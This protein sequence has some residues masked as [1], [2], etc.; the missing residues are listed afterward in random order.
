MNTTQ[1]SRR[2]AKLAPTAIRVA[3]SAALALLTLPVLAGCDNAGQGAVSGASVGALS[4]LAIGSLSGN[5]GKGAA[6]GAIAG[7]AGGAVIGDQNRRANERSAQ[8]A[9]SLP[10]AAQPA[11]AP[12]APAPALSTADRDRLALARLARAWTI[13]GWQTTGGQRRL[14]SGTATGS[15]ENAFFVTLDLRVTDQQTG[16]TNSGDVWFASEPGRGIT[17]NSRFDTSPMPVSHIG[18][19]SADGNVFSFDETTPGVSGRRMIIRFLSDREFVVDN[20]ER[21]NGQITPIG[22]L[23]FTATR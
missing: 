9:R 5:A 23:S 14:V 11:P 7:G 6:I 3:R 18:T 15:V 21:I 22:S 12:A 20:S 1:P 16:Q 13:T 2:P 17:V 10:P 4:G 19:L 8:T